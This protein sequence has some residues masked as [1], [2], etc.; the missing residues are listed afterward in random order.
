[1][2]KRQGWETKICIIAF[3]LLIISAVYV[4]VENVTGRHLINSCVDSVSSSSVET[5]KKLRYGDNGDDVDKFYYKYYVEYTYVVEGIEYENK[6]RISGG[7][8]NRI[9]KENTVE[10]ILYNPD[11]PDESYIAGNLSKGELNR[12]LMVAVAGFVMLFMLLFPKVLSG[13]SSVKV[14]RDGWN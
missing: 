11:K 12:Q 10:D 2:E 8:Y 7:M 14:T 4:L 1:M 5:T 9:A 3:V 6:E 13:I